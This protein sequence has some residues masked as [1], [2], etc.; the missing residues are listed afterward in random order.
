M[1]VNFLNIRV[2]FGLNNNVRDE[3]CVELGCGY[4]ISRAVCRS[5]LTVEKA[6]FSLSNVW[7][8]YMKRLCGLR[9]AGVVPGSS[10]SHACGS[11]FYIGLHQC[12]VFSS[13]NIAVTG[14]RWRC[15]SVICIWNICREMQKTTRILYTKTRANAIINFFF[16]SEIY[17]KIR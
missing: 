9:I 14:G 8:I 15:C 10:A 12:S 6:V 3:I 13:A 2:E 4:A 16:P 17:R 11:I 5:S 1:R 7:Y